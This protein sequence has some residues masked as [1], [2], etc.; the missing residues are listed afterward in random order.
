[1]S[2]PP[3]ATVDVVGFERLDVATPLV[4]LDENDQPRQLGARLCFGPHVVDE[5]E[6][7]ES[8]D[9]GRVYDE[10]QPFLV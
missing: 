9:S 10:V 3:P 7:D 1:M 5:A 4:R 6:I 8:L 2:I